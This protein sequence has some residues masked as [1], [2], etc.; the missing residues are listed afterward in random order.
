MF[1]TISLF[2]V[3][4]AIHLLLTLAATP[5]A[6]TATVSATLVLRCSSLTASP[7]TSSAPK[8]RMILQD[9]I[10]ALLRTCPLRLLC[11]Q[12][13]VT[14]IKVNGPVLTYSLAMFFVLVKQCSSH[15][16]H[17]VS[18]IFKSYG[19][20]QSHCLCQRKEVSRSIASQLLRLY[21]VASYLL[22]YIRVSK[23]RV[24]IFRGA[25]LLYVVWFVS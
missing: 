19:L 16:N 10:T 13:H 9:C 18:S 12:D 15:Y 22:A 4:V 7:G 14:W 23:G 6:T 17:F 25:F 1:H 8:P 11:V 24:L 2:S 20:F 5:P 3:I 21:D